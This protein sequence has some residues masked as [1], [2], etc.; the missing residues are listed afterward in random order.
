MRN[1]FLVLVALVCVGHGRQMRRSKPTAGTRDPLRVLNALFQELSPAAAFRSAGHLA[2]SFRGRHIGERVLLISM[3]D[4]SDLR[5]L[6]SSA[7]SSEHGDL[8]RRAVLNLVTVANVALL[9]G[10]LTTGPS[11]AV[12]TPAALDA[13]DAG[14]EKAWYIG[15]ESSRVLEWVAKEKVA[16]GAS[17]A[18]EVFYSLEF[19][20]YL[21]RFLINYDV[22]CAKW[23][24]TRLAAIPTTFPED[25]Q[26]AKRNAAF[27]QFSASVEYGLR[28][29]PGVRGP[30]FLLKS[31]EKQHGND[32]EACRHLALAFTFLAEKVQPREGIARLL[33]KTAGVDKDELGGGDVGAILP[34]A[35]SP[36]LPQYLARDPKLLLPSTQLPVRNARGFYEVRGLAPMVDLPGK[37]PENK[38]KSTV[39]GL[40]GFLASSEK[41]LG[42]LEFGLFALAGSLGCAGT[43]SAVIPLDVVKT[44]MQTSPGKYDSLQD[45]FGTIWKDEGLG[46]LFLGASPTLLGYLYYGATVYPG[47]EFF[48]R[49]FEFQLGAATAASFNGPLVICAGACATVAACFGVCPA[50]VVRIRMVSKPEQYGNGNDIGGALAAI[51][52]EAEAASTP[53]VQL[54]YSGFRPL[55]VRQV[56][57][58]AIKFFTFDTC[59]DSILDSFPFLSEQRW[60]QLSVS[61]LAGLVA[62]VTSS[63][64]SQPADTVLSRMNRGA[65]ES[66]EAP[67]LLDTVRAIWNEYGPPGF[68]L[69]AGARCVW[70]GSIIA[71]QF[72]FYDL[73]R[74][75]LGV[76]SEDLL[77]VLD[78][79][80]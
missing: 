79:K 77:Q 38:P 20:T 33:R 19:T 58:G 24:D 47:F 42:A 18:M 2:P 56:I 68:F 16:P 8:S 22:D 64:I 4:G 5:D 46:G 41:E 40:R 62:G 70:S 57:F 12:T 52:A 73:A 39:F 60:T 17:T 29:Y 54:L 78:V 44:R 7:D 10:L 50:E 53:L 9:A 27:G 1:L 63:L 35:F 61:L 43:H 66:S 6:D 30:A 74:Q 13:A 37:P 3:K 48:R 71:G 59:V 25:K 21:S 45:G 14:A 65:A 15:S 23:W 80:L 32:P 34:P 55:V 11:G 49:L 31:L 69:G 76:S 26:V 51:S 36:A 28:R 67:Q 75:L 72:F